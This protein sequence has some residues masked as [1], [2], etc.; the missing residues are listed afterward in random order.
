MN[1]VDHMIVEWFNSDFGLNFS[2]GIVGNL[3][4]IFVSLSLTLVLSGLIGFEREYYGHAAG[5]R[6]HMLVAVG[7]CLVMI[8]SIYGFQA[9]DNAYI[10]SSSTP[11]SRDPARLAAQVVSGIGFLGAG[12]IVQNGINVKGLTTATTLWVSMAVG[13]ACGTGSFVIATMATVISLASLVLL[14]KV[15]IFASKKN[16]II[17][18]VVPSDRPVMKDI[19]LL[20]NRYGMNIRDTA[21]ELVTYEE[22][23]ALRI[24]L[25]LSHSSNSS[26]TAFV[27][28]LR[29]SIHPL[30]LKVSS[31]F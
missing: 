6:T 25:R 7:S 1:S 4:L 29:L 28:E 20:S 15:E 21:S 19:L 9:W 14:R 31:E 23:S 12:T 18:I 27:D 10:G 3:L 16:P 30:E 5:L 8:I 2:N 22:N 11:I 13:L 24:T 17:T 26:V